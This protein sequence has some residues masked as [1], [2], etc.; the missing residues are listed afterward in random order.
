NETAHGCSPP[1]PE[2]PTTCTSEGSFTV[3]SGNI[4]LLPGDI[5][6][7]CDFGVARRV[8]GDGA[9]AEPVAPPGGTPAS[10]APEVVANQRGSASDVYTLGITLYQLL[11]GKLP[12]TDTLE[13][14]VVME[15]S[16]GT[17]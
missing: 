6:L 3:I 7:I 10:M 17:S 2:P 13:R 8:R 4:L 14:Q 1:W 9:R 11:T 12:F 5:P 15:S 16:K